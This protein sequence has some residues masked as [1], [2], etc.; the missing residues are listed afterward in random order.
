VVK[1]D[2]VRHRHDLTLGHRDE[3]GVPAADQQS[4]DGLLDRPSIDPLADLGDGPG[5]LETQVWL[6]PG[7]AD[8]R[9]RPAEPARLTPLR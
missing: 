7:G 3:L 2:R 5:H 8:T 1:L 6:A 9:P 4:T